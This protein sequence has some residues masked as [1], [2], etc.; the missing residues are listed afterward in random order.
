[1]KIVDSAAAKIHDLPLGTP[2]GAGEA[3]SEASADSAAPGWAPASSSFIARHLIT[4]FG[5]LER[6]PV[7]GTSLPHD[8]FLLVIADVR[9]RPSQSHGAME[10]VQRTPINIERRYRL[11]N[12]QGDSVKR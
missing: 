7:D 6:H 3:I 8:N 5:Q 2:T 11:I 10:I 9:G 4:P 12:V 1:M